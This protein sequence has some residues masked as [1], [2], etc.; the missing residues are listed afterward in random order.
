MLR[1]HVVPELRPLC[2]AVLDND[3]DGR[4]QM[5]EAIRSILTRLTDG[6]AGSLERRAIQL[7]AD[8][9]RLLQ[10]VD[11]WTNQIRVARESEYTLIAIA[12]QAIT[13]ADAARWVAEHQKLAWIPGSVEPG[14]PLPLSAL[15]LRE[16]YRTNVELTD[17]DEGELDGTLP[18]L[19]ESTDSCHISRNGCS[20]ERP[21]PGS[22]SDFL[23]K[24]TRRIRNRGSRD[25][26]EVMRLLCDGAALTQRM[27]SEH[28]RG[29]I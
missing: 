27:A 3:L 18:D 20:T 11:E 7:T 10:R 24:A 29:G 1:G 8:R 26:R 12:G 13:P 6:G 23:G 19:S 15:E 21:C 22:R 14:A 17:H 2:V 16:L 28:C 5:E 9:K 25:A 4:K